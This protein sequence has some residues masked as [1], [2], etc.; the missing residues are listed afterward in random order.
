[1]GLRKLGQASIMLDKET[2]AKFIEL[3]GDKLIWE[4]MRDLA[5]KELA[6]KQGSL[7]GGFSSSPA[8]ITNVSK[9]VSELAYMVGRIVSF[10]RLPGG[11]TEYVEKHYPPHNHTAELQAD[12]ALLKSTLQRIEA[13]LPKQLSLQGEVKEG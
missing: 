4:Y 1:M 12:L 8:T 5:N 13:S 10:L 11:I 7:G 3:A 6:G 9:Q 2:K